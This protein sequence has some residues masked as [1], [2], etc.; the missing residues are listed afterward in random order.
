[1][2]WLEDVRGESRRKEDQM[3]KSAVEGHSL[4]HFHL[5]GGFASGGARMVD[6]I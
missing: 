5:L 6:E 2:R 3:R 1:M 4:G